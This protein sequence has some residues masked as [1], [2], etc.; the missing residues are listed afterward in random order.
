MNMTFRELYMSDLY[1]YGGANTKIYKLHYFLRK[2]QT[3]KTVMQYLYRFLL[4]CE[5]RK[6]GIEISYKVSIGPGLYLGHPY[7]ITINDR[8]VIGKNCNIHKGVTIGRENRGKRMG[9]PR[10]GDNVWIGINATIVGAIEI[11]SNVLIAPN[12]FVNTNVPDN[13]VVIGNPCM[14]IPN[15]HATKSYIINTI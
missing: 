2:A 8:A 3:S 7:C 10:I 11:G 15:E 4:R 6:R 5:E 13:S 9:A 12:A 1:R 14:I